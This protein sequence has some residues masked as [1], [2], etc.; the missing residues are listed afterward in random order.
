MLQ[1]A[2][3][4]GVEAIARG[5]QALQRDG[6]LVEQRED[7]PPQRFVS[8]LRSRQR[9]QLGEH[10]FGIVARAFDELGGVEAVGEVGVGGRTD[11]DEVRDLRAVA[12]VF[13]VNG[14]ELEEPTG[15][16][17]VLA[18]GEVRAVAPDHKS[19]GAVRVAETAGVIGLAL[20]CDAAILLGQEREEVGELAGDEVAETGLDGLGFGHDDGSAVRGCGRWSEDGASLRRRF[21]RPRRS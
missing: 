2:A 15:V 4:E 20:A 5:R 18:G 1:Q 19:D 3:G 12:F 14:A 21:A 9:F 11:G 6:V 13:T 16:P 17:V 7:Q 10:R 8:D